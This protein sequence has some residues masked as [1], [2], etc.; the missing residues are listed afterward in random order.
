MRAGVAGFFLV[1]IFTRPG[2]V[3]LPAPEARRALQ[4]FP[5]IGA[6]GAERLLLLAGRA[7]VLALDSNGLRTLLRLGYGAEAKS[8]STSYRSAQAAATAELPAEPRALAT[9]HLLLQR[10]GR[11]VC[12]NTRPLCGEC[13]V[14]G[15][16]PAAS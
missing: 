9:A 16:C 13:P 7:P 2:I 4:R 1:T 3:K 15:D 6:P 10:H 14:R 12:R 5:G 8:Y 11:T